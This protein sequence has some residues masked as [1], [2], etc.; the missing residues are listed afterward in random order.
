MPPVPDGQYERTEQQ[1]RTEH[2]H[3]DTGV[4]DDRE[5]GASAGGHRTVGQDDEIGGAA[6]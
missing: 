4:G 5:H 3:S 1:N 6:R 2:D